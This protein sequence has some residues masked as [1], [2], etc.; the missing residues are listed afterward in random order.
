MRRTWNVV[1]L[2]K[3]LKAASLVITL[4]SFL[5][6]HSFYT[7]FTTALPKHL[8]TSL[9]QLFP[10]A[11]LTLLVRAHLGHG[12]ILETASGQCFWR[13]VQIV[14]L[15][16]TGTPSG[17][18]RAL[19]IIPLCKRHSYLPWDTQ[20][21]QTKARNKLL[22]DLIRGWC[23]N[24]YFPIVFLTNGWNQAWTRR[25]WNW[26]QVI[27]NKLLLCHLSAWLRRHLSNINL[28]SSQALFVITCLMLL[29]SPWEEGILKK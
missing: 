24:S 26:F 7:R 9:P 17:C 13:E 18:Y 2:W 21:A 23:L 8:N 19:L 28:S 3:Y 4:C 5:V 15:G 1:S 25:A 29:K 22:T 12:S 14:P 16:P 10:G 11:H 20:Q 27:I 6:T